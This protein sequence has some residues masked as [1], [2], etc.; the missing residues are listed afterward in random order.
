MVVLTPHKARK[1]WTTGK[2]CQLASDMLQHANSGPWKWQG[3]RQ[4]DARC[5]YCHFRFCCGLHERLLLPLQGGKNFHAFAARILLR[6]L[7]ARNQQV[8]CGLKD[9]AARAALALVASVLKHPTCWRILR[10]G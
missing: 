7:A 2:K 6:A 1:A 5:R 10:S 9:E 4:K 3:E 8:R